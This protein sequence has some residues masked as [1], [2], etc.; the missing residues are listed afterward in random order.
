MCASLSTGA[1]V[2]AVGDLELASLPDAMGILGELAELYPEASAAD[3][4]PYRPLYPELFTGSEWRLPVTCFLVRSEERTIVVDAGV[5]PPGRWDWQPESEGGLPTAL[6]AHGVDPDGVDVV[7]LTHPHIDHV[8]WLAGD[9][10]FP[11]ARF[12][13]HEDA[14]AFAIDNSRIEWLPA[15]LRDLVAR[16]AVQMIVDGAELARGVSVNAFAGHYPGHVGVMLESGAD[17]AILIGDAAVHPALLDR[18]HWRYISDHEHESAAST[19]RSLVAELVDT[20]T[21]VGANHYPGSGI[22]LIER[23]GDRIVWDEVR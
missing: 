16:G 7:L 12:V 4:E 2:I 22:G 13:V 18:P 8:G 17:R 20:S 23:R 9:E 10:L 1:R 15:R 14:L 11:R 19:R 21:L 5:G 3:W 6:A